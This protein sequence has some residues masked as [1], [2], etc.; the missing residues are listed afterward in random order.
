MSPPFTVIS[1]P[2]MLQREACAN[3]LMNCDRGGD[4]NGDEQQAS[5]GKKN[6]VWYGAAVPAQGWKPPLSR[7]SS[8][9]DA[10]DLPP[11][12][13]GNKPNSGR[14]IRIINNQDHT[15]Q[16]RS[17]SQ[18]RNE[19][20]D[21]DTFYLATSV[22]ALT[23]PVRRSR[24]RATTHNSTQL[25]EDAREAGT[26]SRRARSKSRARVLYAG[27]PDVLRTGNDYS[28]ME[29]MKEEPIRVTIRGLRRTFYPPLHHPPH[30]NSPPE[31]RLQINWVYGYRGM[32]SKRNLW[33]LPTGEMLYFVAAVAVLYDRDEDTQ[34]HY[35][36]HTEDIQCMDLHPSREMVASGQRA[37]RNRK[38]QAHIRIWS[39]ETLL[40][41]Y[42]FGMG[43]FEIGVS[44][45]AFSQLN[46]GSYVLA[47]DAGRERILSVWQW[48]W[49]HLLGK[50]AVSWQPCVPVTVAL[51]QR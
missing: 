26:R 35:V 7:K 5:Y 33:V 25:V 30:D 42:V 40:T 8:I 44:A 18:L 31:K 50:V 27:E 49:G 12:G 32:D 10:G 23:S 37:G 19:F 3:G 17:F 4:D 21:V 6:G 13:G 41:L 45:V 28:L 22:G 14:V 11:P 36:G 29:V 38:T 46:G 9:A 51:C 48:Q 2:S 15:V 43:E 20:A 34:R 24:S 16:V 47:V 39:T 1:L